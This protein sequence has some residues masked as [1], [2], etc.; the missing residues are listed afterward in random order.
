ML[1]A[2]HICQSNFETLSWYTSVIFGAVHI[3]IYKSH[4]NQALKVNFKKL[5]IVLVCE[6]QKKTQS[7]HLL[8]DLM[9]KIDS[10]DCLLHKLF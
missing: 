3:N 9:G 5:N 2:L 4:L 7:L 8:F 6:D 10:C 1:H